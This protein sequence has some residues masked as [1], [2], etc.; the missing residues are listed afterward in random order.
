MRLSIL[1]A[2]AA[3]IA[4]T[5]AFAQDRIIP[6]PPHAGGQ[7]MVHAM[8]MIDAPLISFSINQE[9]RRTPD[10]ASFGAGVT[11]TAPTAVEAM[12]QN[13]VA[14]DRLVRAAKAQGIA[15]RDIQTSGINLSPQYDYSNQTPG[16][17]PRLTGYQASNTVRVSTGNIA[18]LGPLLDALV[19]AG[20][21][22]ID[23]PTFAN[24]DPEA[25]LDGARETAVQR[26]AQRAQLY[27]RAA[28][29][30]AARLV[31]LSEGGA[32][33]PRPMPM[34]MA[35][36]AADSAPATPVQAG[37]VASSVTITVTYRLER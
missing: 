37:E 10:R 18:N 4:A 31:S 6:T 29:Y 28:G 30:R 36:M 12:R 27:A 25:G 33:P 26:A 13:A 35:R 17:P 8:E 20:G 23:G 16:V 14:M 9:I 11:T 34:M 22:N 5:P 2:T 21:T 24:A 3:V 19:S 1:L 15:D 7:P 32:E